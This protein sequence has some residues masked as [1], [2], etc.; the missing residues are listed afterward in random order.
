[1]RARHHVLMA[2]FASLASLVVFGVTEGCGG[3]SD[4]GPAA[5]VDSGIDAPKDGTSDAVSDAPALECIDADI[6]KIEIP[7]STE[8][9]ESLVARGNTLVAAV[10]FAGVHRST[11]RGATWTR[12]YDGRVVEDGGANI[13]LSNVVAVDP[14]NANVIYVG[15]WR[16]LMRTTN[17]G[18]SWAEVLSTTT[19]FVYKVVI[20]SDNPRSEDPQ[21][22]LADISS[23]LTRPAW[24]VEEDRR[25]AI[26]ATIAA[27][28]PGDW[29]L[30]AGKGH[31]TYQL[32]GEQVLALSDIAEAEAALAAYSPSES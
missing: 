15:S 4:S 30:L 5:V 31:E 3:S 11:D 24:C 22:I 20:T 7:G 19:G 27:A 2:S 1:M 13:R 12:I 25:K 8:F 10:S 23:G 28:E 6:T 32:I 17:A 21:R 16:G 29:V 9:V 14:A 18:T 26:A